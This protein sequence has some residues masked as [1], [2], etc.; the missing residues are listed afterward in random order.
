MRDPGVRCEK[1]SPGEKEDIAGKSGRPLHSQSPLL[2]LAIFCV[3]KIGKFSVL[4]RCT[5]TGHDEA[6][7]T[8]G[9]YHGGWSSAFREG[10]AQHLFCRELKDMIATNIGNFFKHHC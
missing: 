9:R 2:V 6:E 3:V 10:D 4:N 7:T 1:C 5:H 8:L